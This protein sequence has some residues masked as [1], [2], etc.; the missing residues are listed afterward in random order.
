MNDGDSIPPKAHAESTMWWSVLDSVVKDD[1]TRF[2]SFKIT[3]RLE[4]RTDKAAADNVVT[5][6]TCDWTKIVNDNLEWHTDAPANTCATSNQTYLKEL[7][8]SADCT[9]VYDITGDG[10]G[11]ITK[12]L[13]GS[14]L[15]HG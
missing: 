9:V 7:Y 11:A 6:K 13:N 1:S 12:K 10:K 8:W 15:G 2:T 3:T 5:S 4:Y 14:P